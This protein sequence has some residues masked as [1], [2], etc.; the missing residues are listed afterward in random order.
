M[1]QW[2]LVSTSMTASRWKM[3]F[4]LVLVVVFYTLPVE[5]FES[6][7]KFRVF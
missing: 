7:E 5:Q 2:V 6:K 1:A 3:V 4:I